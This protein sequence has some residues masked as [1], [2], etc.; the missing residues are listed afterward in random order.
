MSATFFAAIGMKQAEDNEELCTH[1]AET[2]AYK[3]IM[4]K[5]VKNPNENHLRACAYYLKIAK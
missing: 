4:E 3:L 1:L 5:L 2:V